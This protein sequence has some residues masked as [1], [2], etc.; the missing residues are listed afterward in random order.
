MIPI[1]KGFKGFDRNWKCQDIQFEIGK[2][3]EYEGDIELC[4]K[5]FHFCEHP[6]DVFNYYPPSSSKFAEIE[7]KDVSEKRDSDSKRVAKKISIKTELTIKNL[8]DAAVKFTFDRIN[9]TNVTDKSD[10]YKGAVSATG[11]QEAA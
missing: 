7:A 4:S 11:Y 10:E 1:L 6:L 8:V 3:Y 5:G 2:T 9:W